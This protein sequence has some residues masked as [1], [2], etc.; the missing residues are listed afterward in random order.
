MVIAMSR[1]ISL[2]LK[3]RQL[4]EDDS[5]KSL[6]S[7]SQPPGSQK[8]SLDPGD[9]GYIDL[10]LIDSL[11]LFKQPRIYPGYHSY[12]QYTSSSPRSTQNS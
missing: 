2:P 6:P 5:Q 11:N 8:R 12:S 3:R 9:N 10:D 1:A 4:L 7:S